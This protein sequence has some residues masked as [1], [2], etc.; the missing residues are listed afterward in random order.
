LKAIPEGDG[1]LFD[2]TVVLVCSPLGNSSTHKARNAPFLLAGSCGGYF[3][4]GQYVSVPSQPHNPLLT[5]LCHAMGLDVDHFG[6]PAYGS[7]VMEQ[8]L[9]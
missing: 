4:T 5:T 1:T 8:L 7:G 9:V 3:A 2:N 6:D